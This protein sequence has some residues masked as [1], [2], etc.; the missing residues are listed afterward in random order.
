MKLIDRIKNFFNR[1]KVK[2]LEGLQQDNP[3]YNN[4]SRDDFEMTY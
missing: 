1:N 3:Y 2:S 4:K